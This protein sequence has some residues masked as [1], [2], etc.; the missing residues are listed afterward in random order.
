MAE[1]QVP[2]AEQQSRVAAVDLADIA[3]LQAQRRKDQLAVAAKAK[4]DAAAKEKAAA[5]A[6]AK[7]EAAAEKKR[8]AANP[9]RIWVQVASGRSTPALAFD[10]KKLRK[11]YAEAIGDKGAGTATYG[12]TNRLVIGPFASTKKAKKFADD[13][14]QAGKDVMLWNSDAGEEVTPIGGK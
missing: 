2:D 14:Q 9:A 4:K 13:M 5:D 8:I 1:I 3:R 11:K 7:A 12:S 6:K 10:F